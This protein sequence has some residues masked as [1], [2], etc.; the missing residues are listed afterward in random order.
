MAASCN[1]PAVIR[2]GPSGST[3]T[4]RSTLEA[5]QHVSDLG[6]GALEVNYVRGARASE[7]TTR[8]IGQLA[9]DLDIALSAHAPYYVSLNSPREEVRENSIAHVVETARRCMWLGAPFF[10]VHAGSYSGLTPEK[11]T[12]GVV[13]RLLESQARME[14]EGVTG[15]DIGLETTGRQSTWGTQAEIE[16]VMDQVGGVLPVVD[17]SHLHARSQGGLRTTDDFRAVVEWA[18]DLSDCQLYCHFQSIEFGEKG[19]VRHLPVMAWSPDFRLLAP[20]LREVDC[21]VHLICESPL[22][23]QDAL[24]IKDLLEGAGG[25]G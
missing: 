23:E 24:V 25:D 16:A 22:L 15:V 6:L 9:S 20:V 4:A 8:R 18:L 17:F 1:G 11:A 2:V 12:D 7:G 21:D 5:V 10:A 13:E 19:E 14:A 3:Q